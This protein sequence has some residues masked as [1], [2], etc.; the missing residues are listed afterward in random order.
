[1]GKSAE[2]LIR[3][4]R[5]FRENA[6]WNWTDGFF[7]GNGNLGSVA[8]APSHLEWMINKVDVFDP[9]VPDSKYLTHGKVM[10]TL[11]S[12]QRKN[13]HFMGKT[14][15][16]KGGSDRKTMSAAVLRLRFWQAVGWAAQTVPKV[17]QNLSLFD[18]ELEEFVDG[19]NLHP[20]L[21]MFAPR[22]SNFF[23]L[24]IRDNGSKLPHIF[25]LL[26]PAD[27]TL[28]FPEWKTWKDAVGF[29]QVL[30][31]GKGAYAV[32]FHTAGI[33]CEIPMFPIESG[34]TFSTVKQIG[35]ADFF[36]AVRTTFDSGDPLEAAFREARQ[37]ARTG[38]DALREE[39]RR[40]WHDFWNKSWIDFGKSHSVQR[41]WA[42]GLY[43]AASSFGKAPMPGL[44]GLFYG[45][46]G[47]T[48]PGLSTQGYTHDQNAQIPA[49]PLFASNHCELLPVL[50]DTYW[51]VREELKRH[52]RAL[53]GCDGIYLPLCM[54]QLGMEYPV[55]GYRYTLCG[56]AYTGMLLARWWNFS[57]DRE[58]LKNRIHPLLREFVNFY[59]ALMHKSADGM[60]H[61]DWSIPPE[62]FT[63]TRDDMATL[64]LLKPCL[65]TVIQGAEI[66]NSDQEFLPRWCDL[67]THYPPLARHPESGGWHGGPDIPP[68]HFFF[69]GHL[70]YPF[71]PA[72]SEISP[73]TAK[74]TLQYIEKNA[75]ERS[76]TDSAGQW[77]F[78]Y[79]WSAFLNSVARMRLGSVKNS[80]RELERF[81]CLFGKENGLFSHNVNLIL[82]S[83]TTE[84]NIRNSGIPCPV[85]A[86]EEGTP[87]KSRIPES[88]CAS[89]NPDAKRLAP[90]VFEGA[91]AFVF[92]AIEAVFQTYG[93]VIRLFPCV[94][95]SFTGGFHR[96][97]APGAFEI[98]ARMKD[99]KVT[100][101]R[102]HS[103][104]GGTF[105][106]LDPFSRRKKY[107]TRTLPKG[108][109]L[110][111]K[112]TMSRASGNK[113]CD[114]DCRKE[115]GRKATY[116]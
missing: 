56:S 66:L 95:K 67:L 48:A 34:R 15:A 105:T 92:L 8:Y 62:I 51:N 12:M 96:L 42:F 102:I 89:P 82:P 80:W 14:E 53:F 87:M 19:H 111:L 112:R 65:E 11:R 2:K 27:E 110:I 40:W 6:F 71:F 74:N 1:M 18:G 21:T 16:V 28:P 100:E 98:S 103:L 77:H 107:L 75:L 86:N 52:T 45:N 60:Y 38:F 85:R 36:L 13:S 63:M 68:D 44:N 33:N 9:T 73:E 32:V 113:K 81:L 47:V 116:G 94:P 83:E 17:S 41:Y 43:T 79:G 72:E 39:H 26:R 25:E 90:P 3:S 101:V 54:N 30:P 99:G 61:L 5:W 104:A 49:M 115:N 55:A 88:H 31:G 106:L 59:M 37:G 97:M 109:T 50:A 22:G 58:A 78:D 46:S 69:G 64:A 20:V 35:D 93:G 57:R 24:R 7:F 23:C 4:Q 10:K 29:C 76:F 114:K 84:R 91:A 108:K 70:L